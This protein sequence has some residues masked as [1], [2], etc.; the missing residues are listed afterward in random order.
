MLLLLVHGGVQNLP[1]DPSIPVLVDMLGGQ[2]S[3]GT[4]LT[5]YLLLTSILEGFQPW[6]NTDGIVVDV[7]RAVQNSAVMGIVDTGIDQI[8]VLPS[9]A[10][11]R[12]SSAQLIQGGSNNTHIRILPD[13]CSA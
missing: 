11:G 5:V 7:L 1:A 12:I 4:H 3:S 10:E 8:L 6:L 2:E 9:I 13:P